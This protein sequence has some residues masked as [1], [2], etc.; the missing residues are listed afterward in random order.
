MIPAKR[1]GPREEKSH[2]GVS[3]EIRVDEFMAAHLGLEC[4]QS[5]PHKDADRNEQCLDHL[6]PVS[7]RF[8]EA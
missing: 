8:T 6:K 7:L 2:C 4:E 1:N 3:A 5:E